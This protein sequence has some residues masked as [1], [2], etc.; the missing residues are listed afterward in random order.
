VFGAHSREAEYHLFVG[1]QIMKKC[2]KRRE[3]KRRDGG[4]ETQ[5]AS[6]FGSISRD[7]GASTNSA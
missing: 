5:G 4:E 7:M 2:I 3:E 1:L 6:H